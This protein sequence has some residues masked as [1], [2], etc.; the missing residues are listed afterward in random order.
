MPNVCNLGGIYVRIDYKGHNPPHF[1]A[2]YAEHNIVVHI[3]DLRV[4]RGSL[5]KPKERLLFAWAKV[6]RQELM[7]IWM[8]AQRDEGE[9]K[10]IPPTLS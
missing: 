10:P 2:K 5:P 1:H 6:H 9:I 4:L 8:A 3:R 7:D